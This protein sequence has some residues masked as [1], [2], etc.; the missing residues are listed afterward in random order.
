MDN[1]NEN[2]DAIAKDSEKINESSLVSENIRHMPTENTLSKSQLKKIKKRE[3]WLN[4][5]SE[6]RYYTIKMIEKHFYSTTN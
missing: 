6:K 3:K 4:L 2:T 5:K 1:N